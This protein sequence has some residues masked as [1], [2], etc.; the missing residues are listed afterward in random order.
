MKRILEEFYYENIQ[1]NSKQFS[2]GTD[3]DKAMH[4]I[5]ANEDKLTELLSGKEK[6]LFFDYCSAWNEVNGITA[7]EKFINGFKIGA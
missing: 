1:P 5:G 3:F 4:I 7:V 2:R 6:Q